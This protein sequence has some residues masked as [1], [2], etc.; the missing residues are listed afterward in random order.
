MDMF[1]RK[2]WT[3]DFAHNTSANQRK[4]SDRLQ[5]MMEW[6]GMKLEEAI[7]EFQAAAES[8]AAP[9]AVFLRG[10]RFPGTVTARNVK[11]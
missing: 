6:G 2:Y 7:K 8:N 3:P 9:I 11:S 10:R 5:E 4:E 1:F